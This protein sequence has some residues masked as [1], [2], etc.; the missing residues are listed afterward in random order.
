MFYLPKS[1]LL[2]TNKK[3]GIGIVDAVKFF[4]VAFYTKNL[5]SSVMGS[6]EEITGYWL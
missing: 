1:Y 5:Q 2:Y 6:V 3:F 4:L